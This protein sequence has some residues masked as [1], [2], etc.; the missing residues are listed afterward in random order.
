ME[1]E[2]QGDRLIIIIH[3]HLADGR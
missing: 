2:N 3:V 1:E